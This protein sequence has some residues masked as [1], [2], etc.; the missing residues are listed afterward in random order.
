MDKMDID[1]F[2]NMCEFNA[3][4]QC[5]CQKHTLNF[6]FNVGTDTGRFESCRDCGFDMN[7]SNFV[8]L[9]GNEKFKKMCEDAVENVEKKLALQGIH[10]IKK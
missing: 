1:D 3:D 8:K 5:I 9:I 7:P 2:L 10:L 6:S 4:V